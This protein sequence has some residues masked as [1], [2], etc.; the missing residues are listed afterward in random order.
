VEFRIACACGQSIPVSPGQAGS[1]VTC[2][3]GA[4]VVVPSLR[5]LRAAA[6]LP[7][8]EHP[9][10]AVKRL[11]QSGRMAAGP[12]AV[13]GTGA[14][15][16]VECV[17]ECERSVRKSGGGHWVAAALAIVLAA[18]I[19][20]WLLLFREGRDQEPRVF[21]RDL[22]LTLPLPL[23]VVCR[24]GLTSQAE[25]KKVLCHVPEYRRLLEKYPRAKFRVRREVA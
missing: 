2:Q 24:G 20:P 12:C 3:C 17:A 10:V 7:P 21:G 15:A 8:P 4:T 6:G 1:L 23:C 19:S 25:I 22:T 5:Q 14:G 16:P 18:V 11:L 9:E 13:C